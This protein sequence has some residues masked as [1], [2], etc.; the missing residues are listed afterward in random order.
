MPRIKRKFIRK[1]MCLGLSVALICENIVPAYGQEFFKN[2]QGKLEGFFDTPL[3]EMVSEGT[4][5]GARRAEINT[6]LTQTLEE[7]NR[8]MKEPAFARAEKI[9]KEIIGNP[10]EAVAK[11]MFETPIDY[12]AK[13][14]EDLKE[15]Y[16]ETKT[17]LENS[18]NKFLNDIEQ[19]EKKYRKEGFSDAE[20]AAW[21]AENL[22]NIESIFNDTILKNDT[23][24]NE[25]LDKITNHYDEFLKE[26]KLE[27]EEAFFV[28][29]KDLFAELINLYNKNPKEVKDQIL[30]VTPVVVSL[31]NSKGSRVY[32]KEQKNILLD[33]YRNVLEEENSKFANNKDYETNPCEDMAYCSN[34]TNAI[35]G[36]GVLSPSHKDSDLII[37]IIK[38]YDET[39]AFG[40]I[41][42]TG[43][44]ALLAME[45][46]D[47]VD[48]FLMQKTKDEDKFE[49][50]DSLNVF[51]FENWVLF[52]AAKNGKYYGKVS[53]KTVYYDDTKVRNA[54]TDLAQM[55]ADDGS[56]QALNILKKYGVDKC[57]VMQTS[58]VKKE[59]LAKYSISCQ[60]IK[61]F[62]LGALLS[63]KS[64]AAQYS[65]P[66]PSANNSNYRNISEHN[67]KLQNNYYNL[68]KNNFNG[69][70]EAMLAAHFMTLGL[71][72]LPAEDEYNIDTALYK[73]FKDRIPEKFLKSKF[74]VVDRIRKAQK[75][76]RQEDTTAGIWIARAANV[77]VLVKFLVVLGAKALGFGKGV[78]NAI[79]MSK[80][81]L[82][83][84]N[85]PA[86]AK[87]AAQY[88]KEVFMKKKIVA[89][90]SQMGKNFKEIAKNYKSSVRLT[91]LQNAA[92]YTNAVYDYTAASLN[93]LRIS[94]STNLTKGLTKIIKGIKYDE[95]LGIFLLNRSSQIPK[96]LLEVVDDIVATA[97]TNAKTKY[98]VAKLFKK[99]A[100][101][102]EMFL[103]EVKNLT[104]SSALRF[105]DQKFLVEFFEGADFGL[106]LGKAESHISSLGFVKNAVRNFAEKPLILQ[107]FFGT[108]EGKG[109]P[110]GVEFSVRD[111]MPTF[112]ESNPEF[113]QIVQK[114]GNFLLKF[115]KNENEI[116]DFS[117]F[118]LGFENTESFVDFARA[119]AKLLAEGKNAPK[120]NIKYIPKEANTFWNRN[121]RNIFARDKRALFGGNGTVAILGKDGV[122][123]TE[124]GITLK[125][126]KQYDGIRL[127]INEAKNGAID[128]YKGIDALPLT[129]EGAFFIPKYQLGQLLEFSKLRS[130][131][132]PYKIRLTG[133]MNKVNSLYLQSMVSL[134]VA[135]TGLVRP[136]SKNYPD[137]DMG[138]LTFISLIFPYLL[139]AATPFVT[140]FVK[141]FGAIKVLKTSMGLSLASLALP[142][143]SGFHGFGGIQAD[144]PFDKPSPSLL[145]PSALLIGLATTL[146][147]GSYSPLI[148]SI[149]GGSGTLKANAFKSIASFMLILP[150]AIGA[151]IDYIW[152]KYFK[153]PDGSLY[154]DENG[155][156]VRK[157]WFDFSFSYPV[158]FTIAGA[159]LYKLQKA[160]FNSGI[161]RDAKS[162]SNAREFFK[163]VGA[164]YK[165]L[166]RRDL[167]P[168][169]LS[170]ALFAGAE[171]SFLYTY[172]YS[173]ASEYVGNTVDIEAL[174]PVLA[175][176]A[177][178]APAFITRMNSKRILKALGG[179]NMM[180]YR[181]LLTTSIISSGI[182]GYLLAKQDDPI[183]FSLGLILTS[184]GFSQITGSILRYGHKKLEFEVLKQLDKHIVTSWDVSYPT[185]FI[186]MSAVPYL[187]GEMADKN[188]AGFQTDNKSDMV[189]LKNTSWQEM[190]WVPMASS[191]IG[192]G[193]LYLGMRSKT[194]LG[195]L[196]KI[197]LIAPLGLVSRVNNH[198]F[199]TLAF[200][201]PDFAQS[202]I[203][204]P[205]DNFKLN[206]N[207]NKDLII[208]NGL[209]VTPNF[210]IQPLTSG[211]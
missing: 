52:A 120:I 67:Q 199:T 162:F 170:S 39:P 87:V 147:R 187:F 1:I 202:K 107:G 174:V 54:Y 44:A 34:L 169:T 58:G 104:A 193:L 178:N 23:Y 119:S 13:L 201:K 4:N 72:D 59:T 125:T 11:E 68:A 102:K 209:N 180:G 9:K 53:T 25:Q 115:F 144:N 71:G 185:I 210:T 98:R 38:N 46:Y 134:S 123:L 188:I 154:L 191:V 97:T 157:H 66:K 84:K 152:P 141:K 24:F 12:K 150:P 163:D 181:N 198:G 93:T 121:F 176:I 20:I 186:G 21:K 83:V 151:G 28:H 40:S 200:P 15:Q 124:T 99:G 117:A 65:L 122:T 127:I 74:I 112:A 179:D 47:A 14:L 105:E 101:F 158:L 114:D 132:A 57:K 153:N 16:Q 138:Q 172:A 184:V 8:N 164:S 145:Y 76:D 183:S 61:P 100:N 43:L 103:E 128:V 19:E 5:L 81:G 195:V 143:I 78:F 197:P 177:L 82:T 96:Q 63:G 131:D 142:M 190:M 95:N 109:T 148:Q 48:K 173:M 51:D 79:K 111:K 192:S 110:I 55:L 70:A 146:T 33:L 69:D 166:G 155:E 85:I 37:K 60:G 165:L 50:M 56:P 194:S 26:F 135:S 89:Q 64:G 139:S 3:P 129:T 207:Y 45:N 159:S 86:L 136:L 29:V 22:K 106:E 156:K 149:G 140:P 18:R 32:N 36:I 92:Q 206:F 203:Q 137:M 175:L 80:I 35:M 118:K 168:L 161:G 208:P 167:L 2:P 41:M 62:L 211:R 30:E 10:G 196:N 189:S 73:I 204:Q 182:G 75:E 116:I 88:T 171:S 42:I 90:I 6:F 113:A 7:Y 17:I 160:H 205:I 130:V 91:V 31:V 27:A 77:Y 94:E 126:Y 49:A 133:G 108:Q